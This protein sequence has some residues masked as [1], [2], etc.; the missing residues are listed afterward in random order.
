MA[1]TFKFG[2]GNWAVKDGYALAYNDENN[3]F[4]PLPFD[5]T[6]ASNATRVNKQG[7]I[8]TVGSGKPR[9]D[10]L[11]NTSG[12]LLLEPSR[13]NL[14]TYSEDFTQWANTGSETT[15]T[16]DAEISP[17]GSLNA[18]KLQE[19]NSSF[20]YHRLSK[21]ITLS[22]ATDYS[23]SFFAKKG[24]QKY[25]QLLLINTS[26]SETASKVFDLENGTLGETITHGSA[27]LQDAKIED[28]GNGWYRCTIIA[29]LPT[30]P[31]TFRINLANAATGNATN[32]GMV[33]Y[34]GDGNGDI[35]I[36]GAQAEAGSYPTYY[37]PTEGS[38]VTRVAEVANGAGN[39]TV[40]NDSEGVLY[41]ELKLLQ[42]TPSTNMYFGISSGALANSIFFRFNTAG[43]IVAYN[44]GLGSSNII[45]LKS[46][47]EIDL[48]SIFKLAVKYG[49][50]NSDFS[51]Y[52]NG[53]KVSEYGSFSATTV[54]G[55]D[56]CDFALYDGA[57]SPFY[58][59][60]KD[61][62]VYNTALT[63]TE[64]QNL[65]S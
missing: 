26:N 21:T 55:L 22:S 39:S 6:R 51:V 49:A 13:T 15:D 1:N 14:V 59:K 60:V 23:L 10:F 18:T 58:G 25:V 36:W 29:Q 44:A 64:L 53:S 56:K 54:S 31:N 65:T 46:A 37:I 63:D 33:Q 35:Y 8:E 9:I 5:F 7:L 28:F 41:A 57:S 52:V 12:H 42:D 62:R 48:T 34:T 45:A 27:T 40:F 32:L 2:N 24:T 20:G 43:D 19:A 16:A 3:N 4:K 38:S 61:L 30:T 47:S 50:T 17:D 11:N